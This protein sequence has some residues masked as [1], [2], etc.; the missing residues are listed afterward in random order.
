MERHP[1]TCACSYGADVHATDVVGHTAL[2]RAYTNGREEVADLITIWQLS[3]L[4]DKGFS[5][6][7]SGMVAL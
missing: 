4:D 5:K 2:D 3:H 1:F 6:G 7:D